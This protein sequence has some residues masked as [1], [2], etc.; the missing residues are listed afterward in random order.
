MGHLDGRLRLDGRD[1]QQL[2]DR[3]GRRRDRAGRRLRAGLPAA[4]ETLI[5]AI[6]TLHEKVR[7]GRDHTR[8]AAGGAG[9]AAPRLATRAGPEPL[10]TPVRIGTPR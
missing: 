1:V 7:T 4:P 5:H 10:P 3:P 6:L 2:R 9:P 8:R